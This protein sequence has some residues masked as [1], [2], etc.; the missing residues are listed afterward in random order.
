MTAILG[1]K[2]THDAAV[3]LIVDGVLQFSVELEKVANG[4]RYAKCSSLRE[5]DSVLHSFGWS[6][7]DVNA[8]VIDGWKRS[9]IPQ[10][11]LS[12]APYHEH[13]GA[14][15]PLLQ[16]ETVSGTS[17]KNAFSYR[18][19]AGHVIGSYVASP[20]AQ[21]GEPAYCITWDGGLQPRA[22][23]IDPATGS[24][25]FIG[26]LFELYGI[27]YGIMGHYFGPYKKSA[28]YELSSINA[29][30]IINNGWFGGYDIPGKLMSYIALGHVSQRLLSIIDKAY[31]QAEIVLRHNP[32]HLSY[33]QTGVPEHDMCRFIRSHVVD[34]RDADV[35]A[36]IHFFLERLLVTRATRAMPAGSNL[37]FTGGSA[38]NIKWNTALRETG[39][40][41]DVFVPPFPNDCGS[42]IGAAACHAWAGGSRSLAWDVYSGPALIHNRLSGWSKV[43]CSPTEL[44]QL[45]AERKDEMIVTLHGRAEL[46]PR[47]LG[48]RSLLM[49]P[50]LPSNQPRLNRAKNRESFRPVAPLC[51]E[52]RAQEIFSPGKPD[53]WMLFDHEVREEW[54]HRIPAVVHVDGTARLQTINKEQCPVTTEIIESYCERTGVP[55]LCNTSANLP[56]CGFFPDVASAQRWAQDAGVQRVWADGSLW[57]KA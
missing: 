11:G 12:V 16:T 21:H 38:L 20:Y 18:H 23:K 24:V 52:H 26:T 49:S 29:E 33:N 22:H 54:G 15:L 27:I 42:A 46:G 34:E 45:L 7:D 9:T 2:L 53:P 35:L 36:T 50:E 10:W 51:L 41:K 3:A 47:S 30:T 13:D 44:G 25:E 14:L 31:A 32:N 6:W 57:S 1:L 40:F 5:I 39:H 4:P 37:I 8:T 48:H 56:G 28:I 17:F 19:V 55:V 43:T